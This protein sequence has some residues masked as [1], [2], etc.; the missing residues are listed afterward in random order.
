MWPRSTGSPST[1]T[2]QPWGT[3]QHPVYFYPPATARVL[4]PRRDL[5]FVFYG[6]EPGGRQLCCSSQIADDAQ[7]PPGASRDPIPSQTGISPS[8]SLREAAE[9]PSPVR[10][11]TL[12]QCKPSPAAPATPTLLWDSPMSRKG[13]AQPAAPPTRRDPAPHSLPNLAETNHGV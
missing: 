3:H 11:A 13:S 4:C 7:T 1:P 12:D 2:H 6:S 9:H 5:P 10:L 8:P